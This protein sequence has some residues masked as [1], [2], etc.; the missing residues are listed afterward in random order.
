MMLMM[1]TVVMVIMMIT[2]VL[3]VVMMMMTALVVI[4]MIMSVV[5]IIMMM[6]KM[7]MMMKHFFEIC[8]NP[9][10]AAF[11][12]EFG[13]QMGCPYFSPFSLILFRLIHMIYQW[14]GFRS[15]VIPWLSY[16]SE[17]H[18]K[19]VFVSHKKELRETS[20]ICGYCRKDATT[21]NDMSTIC[22]QLSV[23]VV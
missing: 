16:D 18:Y 22:L 21:C 23:E 6:M 1:V 4:M 3:E 15:A 8:F 19:L 2:V 10:P 9:Y 20:A 14:T 12:N 11:S 5:M 7:T 17:S 13:L